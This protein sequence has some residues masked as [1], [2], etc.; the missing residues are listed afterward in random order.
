[1]ISAFRLTSLQL[2]LPYGQSFRGCFPYSIMG[3]AGWAPSSW[4]ATISMPGPLRSTMTT[5]S[6]YL[7]D[8]SSGGRGKIRPMARWTFERGKSSPSAANGPA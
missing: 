1:M 7:P 2:L 5:F 3:K 6:I 8:R 4:R